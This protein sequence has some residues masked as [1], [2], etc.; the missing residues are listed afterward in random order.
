MD[1]WVLF[2]ENITNFNKSMGWG[3]PVC[4]FIILQT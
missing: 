1:L 4:L 3:I 2:Q